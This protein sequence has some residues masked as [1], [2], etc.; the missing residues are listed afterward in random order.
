MAHRLTRAW[1]LAQAEK[2]PA[3]VDD[4]IADL[5]GKARAKY[6]EVLRVVRWKA[7]RSSGYFL[8][9]EPAVVE[10]R[11]REA[12][13]AADPMKALDILVQLQGVKE[14]MA[15]AILAAFRPD[16]Y[17]VMDWRAWETLVSLGLVSDAVGRNWRKRWVP[18]LEACRALAERF[19]VD[20]R[21]LDRALWEA[22]AK[23]DS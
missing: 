19:D 8:R 14:R 4:G 10:A 16:R 6:D 1:I 12:L 22:G 7:A 13:A 23:P 2:Y 20:L 9:N 11:V 21:T 15:S 17:T 18:Y 3:E 5:A